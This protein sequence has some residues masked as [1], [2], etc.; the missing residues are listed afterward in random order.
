MVDGSLCLT[1]NLG[2]GNIG[3]EGREGDRALSEPCHTGEGGEESHRQLVRGMS[4]GAEAKKS[5]IA[6]GSELSEIKT[7]R[8][9]PF[10]RRL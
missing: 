5:P 7:R 6:G 10:T 9:Q 4:L 1:G 2:R 3:P 8:N